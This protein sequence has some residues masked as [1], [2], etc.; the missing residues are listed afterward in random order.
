MNRLVLCVAVLALAGAC[1]TK[2]LDAEIRAWKAEEVGEAAARVWAR[3]HCRRHTITLSWKPV[4]CELDH[5][6]ASE[7]LVFVRWRAAQG[8]AR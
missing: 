6:T 5:L 7:E 2:D 1:E 3:R 4:P 8:G